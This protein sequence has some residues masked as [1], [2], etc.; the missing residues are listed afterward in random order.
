MLLRLLLLLLLD[1]S[2]MADDRR[3][4]RLTTAANANRRKFA[5]TR[6]HLVNWQT[7]YNRTS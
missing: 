3:D 5:V 6:C 4:N 7:P 2:V 1:A